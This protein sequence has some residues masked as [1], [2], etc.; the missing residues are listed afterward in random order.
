MNARLHLIKPY[1]NNLVQPWEIWL[2]I[3]EWRDRFHD[4]RN[5]PF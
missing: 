3:R 1:R 4:K 2:A 5:N